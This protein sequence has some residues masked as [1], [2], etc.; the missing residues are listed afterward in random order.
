MKNKILL[1]ITCLAFFLSYSQEKITW[2]H[3]A[4]V[5]YTEKFFPSYDDYFLYPAFSTTMKS[6]SGKKVTISGYFLDVDPNGQLFILS[7]GPMA[8]CF[9]CGVGGPETAME[10]QFKTKPNFKTDDVVSITGILKLNKD[11]VEHFNYIL[12]ECVGRL[13]E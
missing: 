2:E 11:D 10:L 7:K 8:S 13:V 9:F 1:T 3:L 4:E 12:T 6:L 5:T